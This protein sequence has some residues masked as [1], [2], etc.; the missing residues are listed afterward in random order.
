MIKDGSILDLLIPRFKTEPFC[1]V[2]LEDEGGNTAYDPVIPYCFREVDEWFDGLVD[3]RYLNLF[4]LCLFS[5]VQYQ[6]LR[7]FTVEDV[8]RD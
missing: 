7:K 4:G 2:K 3:I 6:T 5:E 1:L 8:L